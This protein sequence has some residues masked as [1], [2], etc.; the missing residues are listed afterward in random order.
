MTAIAGLLVAGQ[1]GVH[2]PGHVAKQPA[3]G[4]GCESRR[5]LGSRRGGLRIGPIGFRFEAL[6]DFAE[7]RFRDRALQ[8]VQLLMEPSDF[9]PVADP[10]GGEVRSRPGDFGSAFGERGFELGQPRAQPVDVVAVRL[11]RH[12]GHAQ[13][14]S[15]VRARTTRA[16]VA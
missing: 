13:I 4:V 15:N 10:E 16:T 14:I 8:V 6:A 9:L 3:H 11:R 2:G 1:V 12:E 7:L 5:R